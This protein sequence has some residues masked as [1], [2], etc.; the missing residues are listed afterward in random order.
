MADKLSGWP[1][2]CSNDEGHLMCVA[3]KCGKVFTTGDEARARSEHLREASIAHGQDP[4]TKID[5]GILWAMDKQ[6]RCP[7]CLD[8]EFSSIKDLYDHDRLDHKFESTATIP[9]F[10]WHLREEHIEE[11]VAKLAYEPVHQRLLHGIM[12]WSEYLGELGLQLFWHSGGSQEDQKKAIVLQIRGPNVL[13]GRPDNYPM[14]SK[15]FL[16]DKS[17][18]YIDPR[19]RHY[20]WAGKRSRLLQMYENA[21]I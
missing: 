9:G 4:E 16:S 18:M 17:A 8:F 12:A 15:E 21:W 13:E 7:W 1:Q 2:S 20:D 5:H 14:S 11:D 6:R 3:R 19:H 10:V